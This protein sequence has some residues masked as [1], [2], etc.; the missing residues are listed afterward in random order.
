MNNPHI[1]DGDDLVIRFKQDS[2]V[3][4]FESE[5]AE[6]DEPVEERFSEGEE[7]EVT[8]FGVDEHKIDVQF[9]DCSIAF[10]RREGIEIISVN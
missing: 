3:E 1:E 9:G 8:V 6:L 10:I 7:V 2:I 5:D 4:V